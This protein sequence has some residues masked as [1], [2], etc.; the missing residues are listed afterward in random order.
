[1]AN[2][3][4]SLYMTLMGQGGGNPYGYK[5]GNMMDEMSRIMDTPGG[6]GLDG[7][8]SMKQA[9]EYFHMRNMLPHL[10]QLEN[11]N[12]Q[13]GA[14]GLSHLANLEQQR[15]GFL[16]DDYGTKQRFYKQYGI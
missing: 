10:V 15:R 7:G 3:Y 16:A 1:M 14:A 13:R 6:R 4:T 8:L 9:G 11:A 2:D 12:A 5:A